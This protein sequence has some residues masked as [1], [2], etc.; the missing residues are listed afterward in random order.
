MLNDRSKVG[1]WISQCRE[2]ADEHL[3]QVDQAHTISVHDRNYELYIAWRE[4][5]LS[6]RKLF[7]ALS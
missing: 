2:K 5:E 3:S 4:A 7:N 6:L 1:L